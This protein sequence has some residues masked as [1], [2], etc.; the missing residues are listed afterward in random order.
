MPRLLCLLTLLA[1]LPSWSDTSPVEI[2]LPHLRL[3]WTLDSGLYVTCDGR[4]VRKEIEH[5]P[6]LATRQHPRPGYA[7]RDMLR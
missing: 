6:T 4:S 2:A 7:L 1:A 5:A 3:H